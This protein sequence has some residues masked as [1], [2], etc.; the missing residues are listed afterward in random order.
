[1]TEQLI[2]TG[3]GLP[4]YPATAAL[5]LRSVF[6][7]KADVV[8]SSRRRLAETLEVVGK[9]YKSIYILGVGLDVE[10][11]KNAETMIA[12]KKAGVR[13]RWISGMAIPLEILHE[14]K[15]RSDGWCFAEEPIID[16]RGLF[17]AIA[18]AFPQKELDKEIAFF[19]KF[20]EENPAKDSDVWKY[21]RLFEA[22][23]W[24]HRTFRENDAYISLIKLLAKKTAT[25]SFPG[26]CQKM[27]DYYD[28]WG[29]RKLIGISK[30]M[31][32]VREMI[33]IAAAHSEPTARVLITGPSGTGKE[34][35]A[36][37]IHMLSSRK[38]GPFQSFNC[39]CTTKEL[40]E[41][42]LF[43]HVKGAFTGAVEDAEG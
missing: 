15:G 42:K 19:S 8:V 26:A 2:V 34:T 6:D 28:R 31:D 18:K 7:F 17:Q 40:F 33:K 5:A 1:M 3:W 9:K 14:Y 37:Q 29:K 27:L 21:R 13:V 4:V 32:E 43:G 16:E 23:D 30:H 25:D 38:D 22:A 24:K 20:A 11:R 35:V 12:L 10:P 41:A 39:A 36:Q